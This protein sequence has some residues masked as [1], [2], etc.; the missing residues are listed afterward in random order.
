[1]D[2]GQQRP[3]GA[4]G[5]I[6]A[7]AGHKIGADPMQL[8]LWSGL[9][10]RYDTFEAAADQH[11]RAFISK[12]QPTRAPAQG[13]EPRPLLIDPLGAPQ[14]DSSIDHGITPPVRDELMASTPSVASWFH[15]ALVTGALVVAVGV[16]WLGGA[17]PSFFFA[18]TAAPVQQANSSGCARE[19]GKD[20]ACDS[21]KTDREA[22]PSAPAPAKLA[23]PG[24]GTNRAREPSRGTQQASAAT[25]DVSTTSSIAR[26]RPRNG[27]RSS[28]DPRR[29]RRRGRARSKVGAFA[30]SLVELSCWRGRAA[31]GERRRETPCRAS[32]ASSRLSAGAAAGSSRP[33]KA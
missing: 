33:A 32:D 25:K 6:C 26:D 15:P 13:T 16:G 3:R 7:D 27:Q 22:T 21:V 10:P 4:I 5:A 24:A 31:F 23:T 12:T 28:P 14:A 2:D 1:M 20:T 9:Q 29:Y 11:P 30:R 17:S 19:S 8:D 18:P